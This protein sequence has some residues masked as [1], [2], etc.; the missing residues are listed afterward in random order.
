MRRTR[1]ILRSVLMVCLAVQ[2]SAGQQVSGQHQ[3]RQKITPKSIAAAA[4]AKV[5]YNGSPQFAPI[6]GTSLS[7]ATN[8]PQKIIRLGTVYY[9]CVEKYWVVSTD[10]Q[11]PWKTAQSVPLEITTIDCVELGLFNAYGGYML[12]AAPSPQYKDQDCCVVHR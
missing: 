12:C 6:E 4:Q 10:P 1:I 11:G 3:I 8:T 2:V 7:Y 5:S 9:L